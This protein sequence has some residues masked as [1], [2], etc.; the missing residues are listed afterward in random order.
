MAGKFHVQCKL[1]KGTLVQYSWIPEKF[2]KVGK[3]IKLKND[4]GWKVIETYSRELSKFVS[5]RQMDYKHQREV[6]DI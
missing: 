6:S 4:N 5:E 1:Q 3:Y 2:A